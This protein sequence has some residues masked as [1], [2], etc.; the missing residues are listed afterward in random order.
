[1]QPT[2]QLILA[3]FLNDLLLSALNCQPSLPVLKMSMAKPSLFFLSNQMRKR[4]VIM[5][6]CW[7]TDVYLRREHHT[8][9]LVL[10]AYISAVCVYREVFQM[11]P[12]SRDTGKGRVVFKKLTSGRLNIPFTGPDPS[13]AFCCGQFRLTCQLNGGSTS[14]NYIG[15]FPFYFPVQCCLLHKLFFSQFR[16]LGY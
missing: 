9:A 1:M 13:F 8:E 12:A 16:H 11:C 7:T 10:P 4:L 5:F 14:S 15:G 6:A 2:N 3:H